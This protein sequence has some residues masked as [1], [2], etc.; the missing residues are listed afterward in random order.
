MTRPFLTSTFPKVYGSRSFAD[1][2]TKAQLCAEAGQRT[3]IRTPRVLGFDENRYVIDYEFLDCPTSLLDLMSRRSTSTATLLAAVEQ[4]G[5]ALGTLHRVLPTE[6][7]PRFERR[8][9]FD[10]ALGEDRRLDG[11]GLVLQHGDY[12]YS[13]IRFS[14]HGELVIIDPSPNQYVTSHPLNVDYPE[15]DLALITSNFLGRTVNPIA[16]ARTIRLGSELVGALLR[17]YESAAGPVDTVRL[18][19][20]TRATIA[21]FA[22]WYQRGRP[23]L[24]VP[25]TRLLERNLPA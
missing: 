10:R 3:G 25:L 15:L 13:N 18:R 24:L 5:A 14:R 23:E 2:L 20:Y 21:A 16:M 19:E 8:E 4:S 1:E 9:G 11:P 6:G 17:G 12:G 22:D 7:F